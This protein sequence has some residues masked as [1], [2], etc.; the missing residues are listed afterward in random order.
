MPNIQTANQMAATPTIPYNT[1]C[2]NVTFPRC[3]NNTAAGALAAGVA[4]AILQQIKI[5][6][7]ITYILI[8]T[9][10]SLIIMANDVKIVAQAVLLKKLVQT[11][12]RNVR[13][14]TSV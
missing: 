5:K 11:A 1:I 4:Q 10:T 6:T 7:I 14:K 9:N 13:A 2:Q 3:A 8:P 12:A